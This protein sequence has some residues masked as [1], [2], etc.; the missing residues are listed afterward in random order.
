MLLSEALGWYYIS[1]SGVRSPATEAFYKVRL[2]SLSAALGDKEISAITT[3]DLELWRG[4]LSNRDTKYLDDKFHHAQPGKLSANYIDQHVRCCRTFFRWLVKRSY[5]T[6]S[7]AID[8]ERPPLP[9]PYVRGISAGS[10]DKILKTA[11]HN[12]RDYAILMILSSSACRIG[13]LVD[14][15][16]SDLNLDRNCALVHEKGRGG[17]KKDRLIRFSPQT[18]NAVHAWLSVRTKMDCDSD[19]LFIGYHTTDATYKPL[20]RAGIR[21]ILRRTATKAGVQKGFNAHNF[22]HAAIRGWLRAGMPLS[23]ASELA[24]HSSV[25]VTANIYGTSDDNDL[26]DAFRRWNTLP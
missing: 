22:R 18:V 13:G 23:K 21:E 17:G 5:I 4:S 15:R 3:L 7:P 2:K 20:K 8:L 16:V 24:G 19:N 11:S 14:L 6:I 12:P 9:K 10:R 25:I 26:D 1:I